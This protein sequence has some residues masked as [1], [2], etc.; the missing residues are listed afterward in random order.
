MQIN[1][2]SLKNISLKALPA[3]NIEMKFLYEKKPS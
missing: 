1:K 2:L 3:D